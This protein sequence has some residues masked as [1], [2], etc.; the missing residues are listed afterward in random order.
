M[1]MHKVSSEIY[2]ENDYISEKLASGNTATKFA[3]KCPSYMIEADSTVGTLNYDSDDDLDIDRDREGIIVIEHS[4]STELNLVGLQVWRAAFL[5][6]DY[7]LSH[8]DLFRNQIIL[9]LGSGVGLTSIVASYL[10]KEVICTDINVGDILNLIKRNFL[11]NQTY[12]KSSYHIEEVNFLSL[13]WSKK[14][15][16]KLQ[17]ANIVLAADVIY[18]DK[19]TDGFVRTLTKLLHTTNKKTIYIALEKRYVFTVADLDTAAPMYEEFLRCIEKYKMNWSI[20]YI[21]IDFPRYFKYDRVQHLV[22]MKIQSNMRP[23]VYT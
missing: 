8:P 20:D 2:T 5:L 9:E 6:A 12:V 22:L 18:D 17:S 7:I 10:A 19:I 14:L 21:N 23:V 3:F 11:R 4:V 1:V 13:E 15:E 16:E